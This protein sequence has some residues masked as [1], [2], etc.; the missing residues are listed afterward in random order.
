MEGHLGL[1]LHSVPP[2]AMPPAV[3][4]TAAKKPRDR[5]PIAGIITKHL[6]EQVILNPRSEKAS[7][8]WIIND[9]SNRVWPQVRLKPNTIRNSVLPTFR[10]VS[11]LWAAYAALENFEP[12]CF[13]CELSNLG[14]FLSLAE[15]YR[16]EGESR[17]TWQSP[18]PVLPMGEC[19]RLPAG[20][21][22]PKFTLPAS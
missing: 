20:L 21:C 13:P 9:L 6:I 14:K 10:K 7:S 1:S 12:S 11:H 22:L 2:P 19:V 8:D 15:W 5:G 4:R 18:T 16:T 17:S 3:L